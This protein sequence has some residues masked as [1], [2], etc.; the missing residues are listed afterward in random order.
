MVIAEPGQFFTRTSGSIA[1]KIIGKRIETNS[2]GDV[3]LRPLY[4][5]SSGF[6]LSFAYGRR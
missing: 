2:T 6:H 1:K 3:C 4:L 5:N